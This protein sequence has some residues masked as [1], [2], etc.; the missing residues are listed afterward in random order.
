VNPRTF[1]AP[2]SA[3]LK[4]ISGI[5]TALM[6]GVAV[7]LLT[8]VPQVGSI[9]WHAMLVA[10]VPLCALPF[11]VLGYRLEG[12][13]LFVHRPGWT[14]RVDLSGLVSAEAAPE[15]A[16]KSWRVC[17]N[18]GLFS[19]TGCFYARD[20]GTYRAWFNDPAKVVL[21]HLPGRRIAVSPG[22][23]SAFIQTLRQAG[24]PRH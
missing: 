7:I 15:L 22:D 16:G 18:G 20:V 21:L 1:E 10:A 5:A 23:P 4:W 6:I 14:K 11:R 17:G 12:R 8:A 19:F 3:S 9:P 13:V 24:L 2:W